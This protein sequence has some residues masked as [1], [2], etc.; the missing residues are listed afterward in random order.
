[1]KEILVQESSLPKAYHKALKQLWIYGDR[2]DCPDWNTKRLEAS[3]TIVVEHPLEEPMISKFFPGGYTDLEQYK[4]EMLDGILDFEIL[5]GNWSYTYHDRYADQYQ[6]II[7]DLK[8]NPQST[9]AVMDIR[10]KD[11]VGSDDPACWQHVQFLVR[12]DKLDMKVLFR[13]NDAVKA[14]FMNMFALIMLQKKV[15]DEL[16]VDVGMYI[17]RANSFHAYEQD[18]ESLHQFVAGMGFSENTFLYEGDG[19][20]KELMEDD[21][22][23]EEISKKVQILKEKCKEMCKIGL[24]SQKNDIDLH[25]FCELASKLF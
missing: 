3:M 17:H 18:W 4:Q 14:S 11:D 12:D 1:M 23:Q 20:W 21:E 6:F 19:G 7:D 15:A 8:R 22:T 10:T 2:Y 13:S 16:G 25:H 9:R 24:I 5:T